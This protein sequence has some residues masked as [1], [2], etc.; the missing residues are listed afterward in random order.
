M[1][2]DVLV[3]QQQY[4]T[5][6]FVVL[7]FHIMQKQEVIFKNNINKGIKLTS[8]I[9]NDSQE[10]YAIN[11]NNNLID[12]YCNSWGPDDDGKIFGKPGKLTKYAFEKATKFVIY[13]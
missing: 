11:F 9:V 4:Q 2:L 5:I 12:I 8:T 3:K 10:A 6:I 13:Y 1:E 7:V